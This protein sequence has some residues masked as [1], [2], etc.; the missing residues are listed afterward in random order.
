MHSLVQTHPNHAKFVTTFTCFASKI[1]LQYILF[2]QKLFIQFQWDSLSKITI[3]CFH[4]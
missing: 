4:D 2:I 1:I 3:N